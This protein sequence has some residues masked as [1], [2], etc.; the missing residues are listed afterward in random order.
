MAILFF[1]N[2]MLE[3]APEAMS[4]TPQEQEKTLIVRESPPKLLAMLHA[5]L[6][7]VSNSS[8]M[9]SSAVIDSL[10]KHMDLGR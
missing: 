2:L 10:K 8:N 7:T 4:S 5:T 9:D 6:R 3:F 1:Q